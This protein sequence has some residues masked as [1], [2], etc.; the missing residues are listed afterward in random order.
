MGQGDSTE[1]IVRD[2]HSI[3]WL[4][5]QGGTPDPV[6]FRLAMAIDIEREVRR[7]RRRIRAM[8]DVDNP[9]DALKAAYAPARAL[10]QTRRDQLEIL[11]PPTDDTPIDN[12]GFAEALG[13]ESQISETLTRED[14]E[15]TQNTDGSSTT[16]ATRTTARRVQRA[17]KPPKPPKP[18]ADGQSYRDRV[19]EQHATIIRLLNEH[20]PV[21]RIQVATGVSRPTITKIRDELEAARDR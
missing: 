17:T 2:E 18:R 19:V 5:L 8:H 20:V 15:T 21:S 7:C 10:S 3:M 13:L 16:R 1:V 9:V 12:D 14:V 11:Y 6:Q 4:L